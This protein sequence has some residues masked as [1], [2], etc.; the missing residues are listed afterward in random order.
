MTTM[1]LASWLDAHWRHALD[2]I[3]PEGYPTVL[4][5]ARKQ[6]RHVFDAHGVK[7]LFT[8]DPWRFRDMVVEET[9]I[10][11][12]RYNI[13]RGNFIPLLGAHADPTCRALS[14]A[15]FYA[16]IG[17]KTDRPLPLFSTNTACRYGMDAECETV[18]HLFVT[19][20]LWS[21]HPERDC[22]GLEIGRSLNETVTLPAIHVGT[23]WV[24][25]DKRGQGIASD[26]VRLHRMVAWLRFGALPIFGTVDEKK[27]HNKGLRTDLGQVIGRV[28]EKRGENVRPSVCHLYTSDAIVAD[29]Q[30]A[31]AE[32]S[33]RI[34]KSSA[35]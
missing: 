25:D 34:V 29:S 13:H 24:R 27:D 15:N 21:D 10:T 19:K 2:Q 30:R 22:A 33:D 7:L 14:K 31:L 3:K 16:L 5:A 23:A 26:V 18:G 4:S 8:D 17:T 12:P 6:E 28:I 1:P 11:R 32:Q 35:K 20:R 9:R